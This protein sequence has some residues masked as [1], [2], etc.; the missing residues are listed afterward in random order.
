MRNTRTSLLRLIPKIHRATH[1]IGLHIAGLTELGVTQA[2]AHILDHLVTSGDS[3]VGELHHAFAHRRSTLT[4]VM[5]RLTDRGLI[6]REASEHDRRT[7]VIRLTAAG[8][9]LATRLHNELEQLEA[10]VLESVSDRDIKSFENV[11]TAVDKALA[12]PKRR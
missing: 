10:R 6:T 3:T 8:K 9:T 2:E 7:F 12:A 4:S 5:D 11:L 1:R